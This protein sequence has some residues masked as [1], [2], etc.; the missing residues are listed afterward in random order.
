MVI[1]DNA[2]SGQDPVT[3]NSEFLLEVR[4]RPDSRDQEPMAQHSQE[5]AFQA[6]FEDSLPIPGL[7][8]EGNPAPGKARDDQ[9]Q[10]ILDPSVSGDGEVANPVFP[11]DF[12]KGTQTVP[13]IRFVHRFSGKDHMPV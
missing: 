7:G 6:V 12:P 11:E 2:V 9:H 13:Q 8:E 4:P 3:G 10:D 5:K 1:I